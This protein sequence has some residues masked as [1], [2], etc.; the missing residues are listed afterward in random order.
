MHA[1]A[2]T[3]PAATFSYRHADMV[4]LVDPVCGLPFAVHPSR[5]SGTDA[6]FGTGDPDTMS[7]PY[8][9]ALDVSAARLDAAAD[10][11]RGHVPTL[12]SVAAGARSSGSDAVVAIRTDL[13]LSLRHARGNLATGVADIGPTAWVGAIGD[14]GPLAL[15]LFG[16]GALARSLPSGVLV[17]RDRHRAVAWLSPGDEGPLEVEPTLAGLLDAAAATGALGFV[18]DV[19]DGRESLAAE[20]PGDCAFPVH[21]R[22]TWQ[23][24]ADD[25]RAVVRDAW[26]GSAV[27]ARHGAEV[28]RADGARVRVGMPARRAPRAGFAPDAVA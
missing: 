20:Y 10:G 17:L 18:V 22:M 28:V 2:A 1:T 4:F 19:A 26:A 15:E 6:A 3:L 13:A 23:G 14:A 24:D 7:S 8:G 25:A 12:A 21:R 5:M 16:R 11:A 27:L 9:N